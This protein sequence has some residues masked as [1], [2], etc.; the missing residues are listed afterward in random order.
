MSRSIRSTSA[1]TSSSLRA[2][3]PKPCACRR[4]ARI[5][6]TQRLEL[7]GVAPRHAGDEAAGREALRDRAAGR[8][9]GADDERHRGPVV[10]RHG[11]SSLTIVAH[12]ARGDA[13]ASSVEFFFDVGSPTAYLAWTQLP[14]LCRAENADSSSGRCCS[15]ACSRRPATLAGDGA[16]E[17]PLHERRHRAP[18]AALRR[19]VHDQPALPDQHADLDARRG[20]RAAAP[21]GA[22]RRLSACGLRCD[23][24]ASARSRSAGRGRD[25]A[26]RPAASIR[27]R[28]WRSPARP[29]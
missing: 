23:V 7:R 29:T 20:R 8:V 15:A 24:G 12:S 4:S 17:R 27:P 9:A 5:A 16:G 28:R 25:G 3:E 14:A 11:V 22:L 21:A 10:V 18:R 2:S 1:T 6:S 19:A 26:G 13:M